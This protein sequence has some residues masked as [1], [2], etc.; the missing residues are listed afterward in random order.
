MIIPQELPDTTKLRKALAQYVAINDHADTIGL[1]LVLFS[2]ETVVLIPMSQPIVDG[3]RRIAFEHVVDD[4]DMKVVHVYTTLEELRPVEDSSVILP[5][6][7]QK[8]VDEIL[9]PGGFTGIVVDPDAAHC[10]FIQFTPAGLRVIKPRSLDRR[11]SR[12]G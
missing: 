5:Y 6:C 2:L 10:V 7:L 1:S 11:T 9:I 12:Q 4:V 8:L 3:V